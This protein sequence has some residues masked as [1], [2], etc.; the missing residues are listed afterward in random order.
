M[1]AIGTTRSR[2][3]RVRCVVLIGGLAIALVA[4][5][6]APIQPLLVPDYSFDLMSCAVDGGVLEAGDVLFLDLPNAAVLVPSS[7]LGLA[8]QND[9]LDGLSAA[10]AMIATGDSFVL[11]FSVD[12][13]SSGLAPPEPILTALNVPYNVTDQAQRGHA[14]ADQ[15][16]STQMFSPIG[17]LGGDIA[18]NV[19]T[20]NNYDEGGTDF[21]GSPATTAYE[22]AGTE[23]FDELDAMAWLERFDQD[24][25]YVYFSV[26]TFSPSLG[27]PLPAPTWGEPSGADIFVNENPLAFAP[28]ELYASSAEMQL[29]SDDD[30]DALIV[31]DTNDNQLFDS[32]DRVLFSLA[33]GSPSLSTIPGAS[34]DGAA[35]DVFVV[36]YSQAP[37][38]Y[39]SAVQLGLGH[40]SDNINALD[41]HPCDDALAAAALHGIRSP[42]GD[43][44]CDGRIDFD[45]INPFVLALGGEAAF[46]SHWSD[47]HWLHADCNADGAVNFD[48]IDSFVALLSA[49]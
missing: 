10:N 29:S 45:D 16:M 28:T 46:A 48:D 39:A 4:H 36:T 24:A 35:A 34:A 22:T 47:C 12:S 44:N 38:L 31:F 6:A 40:P 13:N 1:T 25:V 3:H 30:I 18:N 21:A 5:A 27:D 17:A 8:T 49:K 11:L 26:T 41:F 42:R 43:L 33:P 9:D 15:F 32:T 23:E 20:R 37:T 14:A 2:S 7:L 19:L